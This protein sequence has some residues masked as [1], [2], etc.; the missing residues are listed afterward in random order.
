MARKKRRYKSRGKPKVN[1]MPYEDA[2]EYMRK[3]N[4]KSRKQYFDW[5]DKHLPAYLPKRPERVYSQWESW[6]VFLG[7]TNSFEETWRKRVDEKKIWRPYWEAVRYA[8][9]LAKEHNLKNKED[10]LQLYESSLVDDDIPKY[11]YNIYPEWGGWKTWLG[12]NLER[13]II[14]ANALEPLFVVAHKNGEPA[15]VIQCIIEKDGVAAL[16]KKW[17]D[18]VIG[19]VYRVYKV[20]GGDNH[21]IDEYLMRF[22]HK[23]DKGVY[24][25]PNINALLFE[26]DMSFE[27]AVAPSELRKW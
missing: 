25:V 11:P 15:N 17:D 1:Y 14:A 24:L 2:M 10:W 9:K 22:A 12:K 13:K 16:R 27:F 4:I 21:L 3:K 6:C 7:N 18:S 26:L 23:R 19:K 8:Q 5:W 20:K